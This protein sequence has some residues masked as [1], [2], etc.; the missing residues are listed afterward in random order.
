MKLKL[1]DDWREWWRWASI[2]LGAIVAAFVGLMVADPNLVPAMVDMLPDDI[3]IVLAPF[4]SL[5]VFL[6]IL[7]FRILC[8][9]RKDRGPTDGC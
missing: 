4:T 3:R 9:V 8:L 1:V 2:Q 7:G 6:V 5:I